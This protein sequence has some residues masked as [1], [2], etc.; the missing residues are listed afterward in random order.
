V[1]TMRIALR[2]AR[3]ARSFDIERLVGCRSGTKTAQEYCNVLA[4]MPLASA[5]LARIC[6]HEF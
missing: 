2:V 6:S 5:G 3:S 1:A 4:H